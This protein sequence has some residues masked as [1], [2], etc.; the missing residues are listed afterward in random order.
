MS[1]SNH[2]DFPTGPVVRTLPSNAGGAVSTT[3]D[4]E[5]KI[6]HALQWKIQNIKQNQYYN[7]F[8]KDF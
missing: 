8:N 2:R 7:K 6:P 3:L 4:W 1:V 5:A